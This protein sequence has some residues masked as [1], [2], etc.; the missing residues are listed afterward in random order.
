MC[1]SKHLRIISHA[2]RGFA[3]YSNNAQWPVYTLRYYASPDRNEQGTNRS[4]RL[5][6][7]FLTENENVWCNGVGAS[8]YQNTGVKYLGLLNCV[9]ETPQNSLCNRQIITANSHFVVYEY[10]DDKFWHSITIIKFNIFTTGITR[11]IIFSSLWIFHIFY[12]QPLSHLAI[13]TFCGRLTHAVAT[14]YIVSFVPVYLTLNPLTW[15]IW[16]VPNNASR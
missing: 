5:A 3:V 12:K 6:V 14:K 7:T 10:V 2:L 16:W 8:R 15:R 4:L 11:I 1:L 9:T 13:M